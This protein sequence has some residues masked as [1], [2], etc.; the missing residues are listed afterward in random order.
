VVE[1]AVAAPVE[2]VA[3]ALAGGGRDRGGAVHAG[4]AG[5][6]SRSVARRRPRR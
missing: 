1:P 5:P 4:E 2:T 6:C 3:A